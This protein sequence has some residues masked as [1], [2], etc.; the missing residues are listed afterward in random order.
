MRNRNKKTTS[1]TLTQEAHA[2]CGHQFGSISDSLYLYMCGVCLCM[3]GIYNILCLRSFLWILFHAWCVLS[4]TSKHT[5]KW[6]MAS[7]IPRMENMEII[8]YCQPAQHG[9]TQHTHTPKPTHRKVWK[10]QIS[11]ISITP[12]SV[13]VSV[14]PMRTNGNSWDWFQVKLFRNSISCARSIRLLYRFSG[15]KFIFAM[16][17]WTAMLRFA[18]QTFREMKTF[19]WCMPNI[20]VT[21]QLM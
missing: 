9:R 3:A 18:G 13:I 2:V 20:K 8:Y 16:E 7:A 10:F 21:N 15:D 11:F 17:Y 12:F 1:H 19:T 14:M 4:L 5:R 6:H